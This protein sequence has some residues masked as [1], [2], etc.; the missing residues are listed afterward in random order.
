M[1]KRD[2]IPALGL[3]S[4]YEVVA[5]RSL[6]QVQLSGTPWLPCPSPSP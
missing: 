3:L 2:G 1:N 6:I 5:V 4:F